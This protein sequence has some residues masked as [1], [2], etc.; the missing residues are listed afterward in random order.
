MFSLRRFVPITLGIIA[1]AAC[2]TPEEPE[3]PEDKTT[4]PVKTETPVIQAS[5]IT[6]LAK[7]DTY[8]LP[9]KVQNTVDGVSVQAAVEGT[10]SWLSVGAANSDGIPVTVTDN[11]S[12][13][14]SAGVTLSYQG[15]EPVKVTLTQSQWA[16]PE[17]GI[18][19]SNI[20]PF[21]ATFTIKRNTG[22]NG[23]YFFEVLDKSTFSKYVASD[24]NEIGSFAWGDALYQSD[25]AYLHSLATQHGHPL[26]QLFGM[27]GSMYSTEATTTMPYSQLKVDSD[28]VFVVY[29]MEATDEAKRKTPICVYEFRTGYS[30]DSSLTFSGSASNIAPTYATI[31]VNPSNNS[32]YWYLDWVSEIQLQTKTLAEVMDASI[33]NAKKYL[34]YYSAKDILC[35][36]P[37]TDQATELMP[38][39]EYTVVA[40][41]MNLE[42]AATTSPQAVFTFRT[43][44][45]PITDNC[46]FTIEPIEIEDMDI[47]VRVT[48][49]NQDTRYYVAFVEKSKMEGYSDEQAAQRII[50]M[51]AQ[52][53]DQHYYDV[54]N[55]SWSNLPGLLPGTREIWGRRD[56]G[57]TFVPQ[58][59]YRIYAFGIDNW[60][61]RSTA[62]SAIDVTTAS[63]GV[64]YNHF[65]VDIVSNTW[66]GLDFTV[67]PEITDEYWMSFLATKS[68]VET[69]FRKPD[70]S[71]KED[72]LFDWIAEYY[73]DEINYNAYAGVR[74]LHQHVVPE[75]DYILLVF[76]FAGAP[77][78][79]MYEWPVSVPAP[80]LGKSTA[81][82]SYTYELFRGEDLT[83][84]NPT[85]FPSVDYEGDCV[86]V[87]RFTVT[88][89][90]KHWYFGCWAPYQSYQEQG[91]KYYLMTLD[92]NPD[93]PGSAMQDKL[94]FR[95]RPWWYGAGENYKWVDD[96]GDIVNHWPWSLSGWAEDAD[97][98]YGP[99]HYELMIPVPL[100]AGSPEL[101]KYEV[102]YSQAY[103]FWSNPSG[104]PMQIFRVSDGA[105]VILPK[106]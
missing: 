100:P 25:L 48:P 49:T 20:G 41:G 12:A 81:D 77:T 67:T 3:K 38:G 51:E 92:M 54:D 39:T 105:T 40:W 103:D 65:S 4:D 76:G 90:A 52:R 9:V 55:L 99:W 10:P 86:M 88:D 7:G 45:Y 31:T 68:D 66:L 63:P 97:G 13:E 46:T 93:V 37:F 1:L 23:G 102:G 50:N 27:L 106:K 104:A 78:T 56:E 11:L 53:I 6:V 73:E 84:L 30:S 83:A 95:N 32:E 82:F 19:I 89:N 29:G 57:W 44:D 72:E 94:F 21:G 43:E 80:P 85:L 24:T 17:F 2:N 28:Y 35:Q 96:E 60:G 34:S 62:V 22:Y 71:L 59:E 16:F 15:A 33:T 58:T 42:M 36:G 91:G 64:S 75:T 18:S 61:I 26:S 74:T 14:R 101:G 47:K 5:D 98:N 79:S 70:G 69:Y 87:M 8:T